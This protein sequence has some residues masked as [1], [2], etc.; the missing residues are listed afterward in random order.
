[1]HAV[2][3]VD[4]LLSTEVYHQLGLAVFALK[5]DGKAEKLLRGETW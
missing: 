4:L 5:S 2:V 1:M 3:P